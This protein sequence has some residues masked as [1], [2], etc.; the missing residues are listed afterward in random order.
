MHSEAKQTKMWMFEAENSLLHG[1]AKKRV[2]H[3]HPR[4]SGKV[5]Y[6]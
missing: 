6:S 3:A 1:P 2:A 4:S 5:L